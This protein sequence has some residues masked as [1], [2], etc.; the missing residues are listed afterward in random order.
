MKRIICFVIISL[1][2]L[3]LAACGTGPSSADP[4]VIPTADPTAIPTEAPTTDPVSDADPIL[5]TSIFAA[6]PEKRFYAYVYIQYIDETGFV[7]SGSFSENVYVVYPNASDYF[8]IYETVRVEFYGRDY[9]QEE[10]DFVEKT[11]PFGGT[12]HSVQTIKEVVSAR[13]SD[14]TLGEDL[15]DKP[16]IY[17]YPEEET[18]V[19]VRL[20]LI[21]EM[22]RSYPY[23]GK[24]GWV[25]Y[26]ARPDGTLIDPNGSEYYALYWEG[27]VDGDLDFSKGYCVEGSRTA[28][29]LEDILPRLGLSAREAEEF[30]VFWL[31]RMDGN[32]YNLIS[33]QF[34]NYTKYAQLDIDPQPDTLIRVFMAWKALDE[35]VE[36]EPQEIV[37]PERVGFTVVEWGG[38]ELH[39]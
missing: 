38:T 27:A 20:N 5:V 11:A 19:N 7:G 32:A 13:R 29:F 17:F 37:T 25:G 6:E 34:E 1:L 18:V 36:I 21:G 31:P 10:R 26:T 39:R 15:Y 30:I 28:E 22:Y 3:S 4:T 14:P 8:N 35:A 33:F 23:Y 12:Y 16:I 24:D 9:C 2:T